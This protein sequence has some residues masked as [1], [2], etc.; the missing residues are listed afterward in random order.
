MEKI[1]SFVYEFISAC[2]PGEDI[3]LNEPMSR[4]TTFK[5]GGEAAK[6]GRLPESSPT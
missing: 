2:V 1:S 3:L 5:V 4:H 6:P